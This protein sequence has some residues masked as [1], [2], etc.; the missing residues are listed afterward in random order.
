MRRLF[1]L[2]VFATVSMLIV[3]MLGCGG[4]EVIEPVSEEEEETA[5]EVIPVT[6]YQIAEANE[7]RIELDSALSIAVDTGVG[8]ADYCDTFWETWREGTKEEML[9]LA[10]DHP[11][12][13]AMVA[14]AK[15]ELNYVPTIINKFNEL[16][17]P[18]WYQDYFSKKEQVAGYLTTAFQQAEG[19]LTGVKPMV[20]NMSDFISIGEGILDF[21]QN[22]MP[23]IGSLI[24]A[25]SYSQARQMVATWTGSVGDMESLLLRAY[26]QAGV[27]VLSWF[28]D[29]CGSLGEV[30]VLLTDWLE[31]KEAGNIAR[32]EQVRSTI[33][34][35]VEGEL[36]ILQS[37]PW[38][39]S[40]TWFETNFGPYINQVRDR[41]GQ[42]VSVNTEAELAY[43]THWT[44][45]AEE[46][47]QIYCVAATDAVGNVGDYF[48]LERYPGR[49]YTTVGGHPEID[50]TGAHTRVQGDNVIFWLE[51]AGDILDDSWV[52]YQFSGYTQ[53][54]YEGY[55]TIGY[56]DGEAEHY[57]AATGEFIPCEYYKSG[58]SLPIITSKDAFEGVGLWDFRVSASDGRLWMEEGQG[59]NDTISFTK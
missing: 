47:E 31:A 23:E 1:R 46:L 35:F 30:L 57:I 51:V 2:L 18:A 53:P 29:R 15:A 12:M 52:D 50:L 14:E 58:G 8:V 9:Q 24:A 28:S 34:T 17:T 36:G 16:N 13:V 26:S 19:F 27:P 45:T 25:E 4:E 41:V 42:A 6:G 38:D 56:R 5:G 32:V 40:N 33:L 37:I 54:D 48:D 3:N 21:W 22:I 55:M 10:E 59:Y 11:D 44:P 39:E 20:E 43:E 49:T 7:L